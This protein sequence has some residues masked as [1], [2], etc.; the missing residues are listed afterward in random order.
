[1][2]RAREPESPPNSAANNA[3]GS[4]SN[5]SKRFLR[6]L[7]VSAIAAAANFGSRIVFSRFC[8]YSLAIFFAFVVGITTAFVL[9]RALVFT[10]SKNQLHQ[11]MLW[12]LLI[13]LGALVLTLAVSLL[14]AR[15]VLPA[16]GIHSYTEEIAHALG[17]L[18]PVITSYLGHKHL[19][20]R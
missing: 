13:N 20:F 10:A 8:D 2:N 6:F 14:F 16:L 12:F 17:I 9:N 11:Q 4:D 19:T 15:I 7:F 5:E 18:A 1:M 3:Q